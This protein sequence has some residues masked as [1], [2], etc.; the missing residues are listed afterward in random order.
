MLNAKT[1]QEDK[2]STATE[3]Q[4]DD[5]VERKAAV[6]GSF[7]P[8]SQDELNG[9]L[10]N[11]LTK[12]NL[13]QATGKLRILI[14]PHAGIDFSG[15]TAAW[16]FKQ[17]AG[18]EYKRV[19]LLGVSHHK[20]FDYA[21]VYARGSWQTPLGSV[22]IDEGLADAIIDN[23][24]K[25]VNDPVPHADEHALE[26]ELLFLQ[27]TLKDFRILPILLSNPKDSLIEN[28]AGK[29]ADN[30]DDSTLLVVSSDLSHY[31]SWQDANEADNRTI[32]AILTG[33]KRQLEQAV[34]GNASKNYA[35][36]QTSAC[37]FEAIRTALKTA[38]L[39]QLKDFKKIFYQN[40]GDVNGDKNRVVGYG[41]IGVWSEELPKKQE[42]SLLDEHAQKEALEVARYTL[43]EYLEGK[44]IPD[45][46]V[47]NKV[48][49]LPY[50]AFVTLKNKGDL[51]GCI[52]EFEPK[53]SLIK[54]IQSKT[55]AAAS[56][57]KRFTP[58][59][60]EELNDLSIEISVM[61]PKKQIDNWKSIKLG[62][63]GVVV[64]EGNHAG[65]FLPQ[66]ESDTGWSKEKFLEELCTQKA[67]L[68]SHCYLDKE[69]KLYIFD[70]QVFGEKN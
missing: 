39:L 30:F 58:V 15:A 46:S 13:I 1:E 68:T 24:E 37:G 36:L 29:I 9:I 41:T 2:K 35:N 56:Q 19:I 40:A 42:I 62:K 61:T 34:N 53:D 49:S 69:A 26:M 4:V 17:T 12:A 38:E 28:L 48:L 5:P 10:D 8:A 65:T 20:A 3:Q 57:D 43:K 67:G 63:Q 25:I 59:Q 22:P 66:V 7:Y 32:Q 14:A 45:V 55:I 18:Q 70:A 50:G 21:A 60:K 51:R 54:V 16:G 31:P 64:Q 33:Q 23:K 47:K 27:K 6:A 11:N 44:A 52:G